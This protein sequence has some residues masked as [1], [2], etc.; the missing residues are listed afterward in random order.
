[1]ALRRGQDER[2]EVVDSDGLHC[3]CKEL[4]ITVR[5]LKSSERKRER[6][7]ERS[8]KEP[9][10]KTNE[11]YTHQNCT[12]ATQAKKKHK[13]HMSKTTKKNSGIKTNRIAKKRTNTQDALPYEWFVPLKKADTRPH[14]SH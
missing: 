7:G 8:E 5:N 6:E 10:V 9:N 11:K 12:P 13:R 1:M 3:I 2:R 14:P 4:I